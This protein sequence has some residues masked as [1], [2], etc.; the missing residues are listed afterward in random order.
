M[1]KAARNHRGPGKRSETRKTFLMPRERIMLM[2]DRK[3]VNTCRT[4][5]NLTELSKDR[6]LNTEEH[7]ELERAMTEK[8]RLEMAGQLA[9]W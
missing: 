4:I 9:S 1:P 3:R 6:I 7:K 2:I 8:T 5:R